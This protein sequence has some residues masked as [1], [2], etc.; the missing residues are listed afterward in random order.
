MGGDEG[1]EGRSYLFLKQIITHKHDMNS[2]LRL[3]RL[4]VAATRTCS[5]SARQ[6]RV[7]LGKGALR[8]ASLAQHSTGQ[9]SQQSATNTSRRQ[10]RSSYAR[11]GTLLVSVALAGVIGSLGLV[12]QLQRLRKG[13]LQYELTSPISD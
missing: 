11:T 12:S 2:K 3:A 4:V 8:E 7:R 13:G 10:Y 1:R 5:T 6:A 9:H